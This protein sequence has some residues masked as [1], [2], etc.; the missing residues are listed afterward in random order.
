M[1]NFLFRYL[2]IYKKKKK[3]VTS[4]KA[5]STRNICKR[6]ICKN[7]STGTTEKLVSAKTERNTRFCFSQEDEGN[8]HERYF[9]N[10]CKKVSCIDPDGMVSRGLS[11]DTISQRLKNLSNY[12]EQ[13]ASILSQVFLYV[14]S[15]WIF[16]VFPLSDACTFKFSKCFRFL[17]TK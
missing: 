9:K 5:M 13:F 6:P 1:F 7:V 10:H 14:V 17:S 16:N 8:A 4:A 12:E 11:A 15:S 3:S 2:S